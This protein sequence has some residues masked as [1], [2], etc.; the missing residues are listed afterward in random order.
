MYSCEQSWLVVFDETFVINQEIDGPYRRGGSTVEHQVQIQAIGVRDEHISDADIAV[1]HRH[2]QEI[3]RTP[4][5]GVP[6]IKT[7]GD[8]EQ[9]KINGLP[10]SAIIPARQEIVPMCTPKLR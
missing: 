10:S 9:G 2:R 6:Q 1:Y 8:A 7:D 4:G 5:T 3:E